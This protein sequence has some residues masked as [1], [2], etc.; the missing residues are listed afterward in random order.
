[1]GQFGL[2]QAVARKEDARLVTGRGCF[3]DD[4]QPPGCAHAAFLRSP[5][6]HARILTVDCEEARR[7]P[8][9]LAVYTSA[10]L[11][12]AGIGPLPCVTLYENRDGTPMAAPE[13]PVLA[14][15][16][17]RFVGD[18]VV[19]VIAETAHAARDALEA[20]TVEYAPL[21][22]VVET[23]RALD[24]DAPTIWPEAP[25]NLALD[26]ET[27]DAGAVDRLFAAARR[28]VELTLVNNRI[29][30][31]PMETRACLAEYDGER[32]RLTLTVGSQGVH[33]MQR[34][35]AENVL[36]IPKEKL[37]VVTRD[38]GGAFGMKIFVFPEYPV[39]LH[40]ARTLGRPV[41]WVADRGESFLADSHGRDHVTTVAIAV[42]ENGRMTALRASAIANLG[43]YLSQVGPFIPTECGAYMYTGVY[44]FEAAHY[45]VRCVF[46]NT[47][48]VDAYRGAGRPEAAYAVERAVDYAARELRCDPIE[49]RR[50]NLIRPEA[51]PFRT[52][53]GY[54]YDS[55]DFPRLLDTALARADAAGFAARREAARASGRLLGLGVACYIERCAGGSEEDARLELRPDGRLR[56]YIGT[57]NNGQGHETAYAQIAAD[58]LGLPFA[59]IEVVQGDTDLVATG[60][61]TGGSRSIPIGGAAVLQASERLVERAKAIAAEMLEAA[62]TDIAFEDGVFRI[63]GT[64]RRTTLVE[65]AATAG[66]LEENGRFKPEA[67]TFP[68]GCHV[69]EL[70]IDLATGVP[71][72]ERYTVVDDF[73]VVVNPALLAGQVHGGLAQGIGQAL[74]EHTVYDGSSG[75]LLSGSLMDYVLPRADDLPTFD[76]EWVVI[77]CRTNPLGVKGAGEAGAIGAPP[78]VIN[79]VVDALSGFGIHHVDMPATPARLWRLLLRAGALAA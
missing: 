21:E 25:G 42:D 36:R 37:R 66:G 50:R 57:Q 62:T 58:R 6:A 54:T 10:E 74:L 61:G 59:D 7:M 43:A 65:V 76:F 18:P 51:M 35:L 46:T 68:N 1:M 4:I 56:I 48:P 30:V 49:F 20:V 29:V 2:G 75:Q 17:V 16:R 9:V 41:K 28:V 27:G 40:A 8:G 26:W 19:A 23:D 60:R 70:S 5:H 73:G 14:R 15:E 39:C 77:P 69:C 71:R 63:V 12:A 24:P 53:L 13:R 64:D 31:N 79:A 32:D 11:D 78:A 47:A 45:R 55:G 3:T 34:I 22:A 52:A 33:S 67:P 72:I 38:V 44:A